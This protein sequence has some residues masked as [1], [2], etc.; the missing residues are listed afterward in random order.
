MPYAAHADVPTG[1][2]L[3]YDGA[4]GF[5]SATVRFV[6]R[7][8]RRTTLRF[9]P[10]QGRYAAGVVARHA[11]LADIDSLLWIE[12]PAEGGPEQVFVRSAA[13]LRVAAYLAGVWRLALV[14]WLAPRSIRDGLYD[15]VAR[16]RHQLFT[17]A[18]TCYVP[19]PEVRARF[20]DGG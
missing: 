3:L 14:A 2:V 19:P 12:T 5:C 15:V 20:L 7:H 16:H 9:A 18:A 17:P 11:D 1:P 4:C 6:L 8:D 13:A 10:L